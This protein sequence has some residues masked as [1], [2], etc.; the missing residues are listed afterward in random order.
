LQRIT[1]S[2]ASWTFGIDGVN[3]DDINALFKFGGIK[4]VA[5][6]PA[7]LPGTVDFPTST[8]VPRVIGNLGPAETNRLFGVTLR[9]C[10]RVDNFPGSDMS[11]L[12]NSLL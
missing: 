11:D 1:S 4:F 9:I 3:V 5:F 8:V 10:C 6:E 7:K 12:Y 2:I